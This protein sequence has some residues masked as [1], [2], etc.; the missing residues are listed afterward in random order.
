M[1]PVMESLLT[2]RSI[3]KYEDRQVTDADLDAVLNAGLYAASAMNQQNTVMVAVRDK[4]LRDELSR[5]NAAVMNGTSDPFYGAPCAVVVFA[6]DDENGIKD[7]SLVMGNLMEA[8]HA[9]GLGSCWINRPRQM[10]VTPEGKELMKKWGVPEDYAGIGI[11]V[12][13]YPAE[14]PEAKPRKE[15]R[16]IKIG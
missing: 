1:N 8:S 12:L 9:I 11:C 7:G 16:I 14:N 15:G 5:C 2:R 3:R 10:F 6:K 4:E 13:G